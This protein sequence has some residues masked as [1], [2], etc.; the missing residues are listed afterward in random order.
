MR[1]VSYDLHTHSLHS[2]GRLAPE[3]VAALAADAGLE[4]LAL[5]DHDTCAGWPAM[6]AA[7]RR[8]G[9]RFVPGVELSAEDGGRSVH[10]LAYWVDA[11]HPGFAA[12]CARLVS[13]RRVRAERVLD[14]LAVL[15]IDVTID[16]VLRHAAGAPVARPHIAEALVEAGAVPDV[17]SAFDRF[18][19]EGAPAHV[20][21]H[22]LPPEAAV[23][24]VREAGGVVVLA[25]P[26]AGH[27]PDGELG[28]DLLDRLT[29]AG[30]AGVEAVHPG[31]DDADIARWRALARERSLLVTGASDFHGRYP[32][33]A[34]GRCTTPSGVVHRLARQARRSATATEGH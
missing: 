9:L 33:E 28:T 13:A 7:C 2:D 32:D 17:P 6:E 31:H 3:D 29:A 10:L 18:L 20:P 22:A 21:K 11:R 30:L 16:A 34:I 14:R 5:T 19:G 24:L 4:G 26:A 15:G 1:P 23:R 8:H 12:E 25:H 27:D